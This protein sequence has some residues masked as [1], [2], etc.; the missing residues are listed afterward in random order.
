MSNKYRK[1]C[2][3]VT[4]RASYARIKTVLEAARVNFENHYQN[5]EVQEI[6]REPYSG[7]AFP[8]FEDI[9]LSFEELETLVRNDRPDW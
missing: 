1:I 8:G 7:R 9:D 3:V 2:V 5:F 4:A 6:L